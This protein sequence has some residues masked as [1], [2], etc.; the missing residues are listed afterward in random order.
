MAAFY[1]TLRGN[2][3]E[4]IRIAYGGVGP[5][6]LRLP[7]TEAFLTGEPLNEGTMAAAGELARTEITP[8][9]DVRGSAD[10]RFHLGE[11]I[12]R[13]FHAEVMATHVSTGGNLGGNGNGRPR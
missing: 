12:V 4:R 13:R 2:V 9:S 8:I 1:A 6:I 5:V 3:I 11:N 10:F 7:K